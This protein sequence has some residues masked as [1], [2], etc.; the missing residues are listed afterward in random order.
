MSQ[1]VRIFLRIFLMTVATLVAALQ[2]GPALAQ[3]DNAHDPFETFNRAMFQFNSNLDRAVVRPVAEAYVNIFPEPVRNCVGNVFSNL[4]DVG[5]AVNN[6]LQGKFKEALSDICRLAINSTIGIFGCFDVASAVGLEKHH[7]DFGQTLGV[8][9]VGSGPYLV[10]PLFGPS[11]VRDGIGFFTLDTRV[12]VVRNLDHVPTRNELWT[13]R[14]VDTRAGLLSATN[15]LDS[16]A[17]DP[18]VFVRDAYFQ[19]R[20]NQIYDGD[21]PDDPKGGNRTARVEAAWPYENAAP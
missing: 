12:D 3:E 21:P 11:S 17:L 4:G 6:A 5:N 10:L 8:W 19:R 2:A 13:V 16:A 20:R 15:L 1:H 14:L 18:Y 7:E 9:G